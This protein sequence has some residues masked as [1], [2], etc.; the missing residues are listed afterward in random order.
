MGG[1]KN[2]GSKLAFL[3]MGSPPRGRGKAPM[4]RLK[5]S[6]RRITP[7]WA[8]KSCRVAHVLVSEKG[9]PPRGRGKAYSRKIRCRKP[10]ITPAWA[11]KSLSRPPA[12][13]R[14]WDH[15]RVGG[16][17]SC[18]LAGQ[19]A[20]TGSPPRGR[21]K[22]SLC[23]CI[24][25]CFGITPAWAGKSCIPSAVA[26]FSG[27]H[28]RVGGEKPDLLAAISSVLGSPPRGRGKVPETYRYVAG[29]GITPA[30]AGKRYGIRC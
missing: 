13:G 9:S 3:M 26:Y 6:Q 21:G 24:L 19:S 18:C 5:L 22:G 17:K 23:F 11:G 8:G 10:G 16:E 14:G 2:T 4:N 7:A 1:E 15:P 12:G 25:V 29:Y 27:D 30:W 28:P 20:Q